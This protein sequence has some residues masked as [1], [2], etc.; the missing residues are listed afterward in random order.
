VLGVSVI[1]G[2]PVPV[3]DTAKLLGA[4][5]T[6]AQRVV[7]LKIGERRVALAVDGVVGVRALPAVSLDDVP[8]LLRDAGD[9]TLAAIATLDDQLLLVLRGARI[10][11]ESLWQS[12]DAEGPPA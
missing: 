12:L 9:D 11:P 6:V 1:R 4:G 10:I 5:G 8:P 7:T 2:V 3:V